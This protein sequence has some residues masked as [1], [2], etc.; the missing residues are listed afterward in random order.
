M[1]LRKAFFSNTIKVADHA[2]ADKFRCTRGALVDERYPTLDFLTNIIFAGND[3]TEINNI[4]FVLPFPVRSIK[5]HLRERLHL[6]K[7]NL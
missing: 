6:A 5:W 7:Y 2:F 3:E 4:C 1:L